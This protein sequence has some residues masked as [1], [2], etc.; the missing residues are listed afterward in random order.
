[1]HPVSRTLKDLGGTLSVD[2]AMAGILAGLDA[3]RH[4][5]IPGYKARFTYLMNRYLPDFLMNARVDRIVRSV[6]ARMDR[7][8]A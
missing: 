1:M 7:G 6:L 5:I 4:A 8:V 2:E 3:G